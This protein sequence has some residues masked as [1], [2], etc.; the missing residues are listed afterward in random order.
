[1][2]SNG[3]KIYL[4]SIVLATPTYVFLDNS[5]NKYVLSNKGVR[6]YLHPVSQSGSS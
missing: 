2:N 6:V 5:G 4:N 1:L 3:E